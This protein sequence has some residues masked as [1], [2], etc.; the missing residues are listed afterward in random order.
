[1]AENNVA[2]LTPAA[3][4]VFVGPVTGAAAV[5]ATQLPRLSQLSSALTITSGTLPNTGTWTSTTAKQNPVTRQ[6]TIAVE[7]VS[8]GTANAATCAIAISADN[9]TYTTIGT[10]TVSTAVNT[11]GAL[12]L[13]DSV[14]L[15][16]GWWIKL[17]F[18]QG[19]V[20]ASI[21]Y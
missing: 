7:F 10:L 1:M 3:G 12:T 15:P 18:V 9:S 14:V 4:Q 5:A 11:V 19:T 21:Y 17:T 13:C 20:A 2:V 16:A 8:N 6:I